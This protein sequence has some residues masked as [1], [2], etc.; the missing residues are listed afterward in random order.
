MTPQSRTVD[1]LKTRHEPH[2]RALN[3]NPSD[4]T[5]Q[6][7]IAADLIEKLTDRITELEE[8]KGGTV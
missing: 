3:R 5:S 1:W 4:Y 2:L 8:F 6:Y 7:S